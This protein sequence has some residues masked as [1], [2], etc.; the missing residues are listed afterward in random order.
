MPK[1]I[2]KNRRL[3]TRRDTQLAWILA[4]NVD[5][6]R[7]MRGLSLRDIAKITGDSVATINRLCDVDARHTHQPRLGVVV[8]LAE[9]LGVT[10]NALI[11]P[12]K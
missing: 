1:V 3:N 9:A 8:R 6:I 2:A 7:T 11:A 12:P 5:R 10:V 4:E